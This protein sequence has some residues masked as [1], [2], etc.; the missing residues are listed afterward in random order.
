MTA[1]AQHPHRVT[2]ALAAARRELRS[3]AEVPV[4]SM[5][6]DET[7]TAIADVTRAEAQLAEL[8]ARLLVHAEQ[9][10]LAAQTGANSTAT[11]H[12]VATTTSRREAHRAVR[13]AAGLD[14]HDLTRAAL[15]AGR[16]HVEQAETILRSLGEL[17][18]DLDPDIRVQAEQQLL[19]LAERHD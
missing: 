11:W 5:D 13:R 19:E 10:N 15:A 16:V 3:V 12:A 2:R 18:D 4:W 6:A 8:K 9:T 17:P 7:T 14:T 1:I